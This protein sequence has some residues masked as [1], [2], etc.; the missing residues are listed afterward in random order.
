MIALIYQRA[1]KYFSHK[2]QNGASLKWQ[3]FCS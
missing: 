2:K 3:G 1:D